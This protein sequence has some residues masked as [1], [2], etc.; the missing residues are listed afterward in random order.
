[1][2]RPSLTLDRLADARLDVFAAVVGLVLSLALLP[3]GLFTTEVLVHGV[4]ASIGLGCLFYLLATLGRFDGW[5]R[6][7]PGWRP[8]E[9]AI[10]ERVRRPATSVSERV[11]RPGFLA[12]IVPRLVVVGLSGLVVVA[13]V[14]GGRPL[15]FL[16]L[17]GVVGSLVLAQILFA[18]AGTLDHRVVLGEI[19]AYAL[20]VRYAAL[21]TT[22]GFVGID[23]WT[24]VTSFSAAIQEA[25]ALSPLAG[26]KY[27]ASP[28]YHLLTVAS[29]E[30]LGV[31]LRTALYLTVAAVMVLAVVL[32]FAT[33][34]YVVGVRGAL[35]ATMLFAVADYVIRWGLYVS[36]TSLGLVFFLAV[37]FVL[38]RILYVEV[39]RIDAVVLAGFAIAVAL[40]HQ[41]SAFI[42]MVLLGTATTV[43]FLSRY[44][45]GMDIPNAD[46]K[47]FA[48]VGVFFSFTLVQWAF[49]PWMGGT[50][51]TEGVALAREWLAGHTGFMNLVEHEPVEAGEEVTAGVLPQLAAYVDTLGLFLFLVVGTLGSLTLL[52]RKRSA[53]TYTYVGAI[54]VMM[55]ATL[56]LP[57]FGFRFLLPERWFAFAY[58]PMAVVGAVGVGY[59]ATQFWTRGATVA[60]FVFLLAFPSTMVVAHDATIDQP[61]FEQQWSQYAHSEAEI[62][63]AET[64]DETVPEANEPI[65]TDHPYFMAMTRLN[66][67]PAERAVADYS[68][69]AYM[70]TVTED[71]Q[72]SP[73]QEIVVYRSYQSEAHPAYRG[74]EDVLT[75]RQ[76]DASEVCPETRNHVYGA[77]DVRMC[78]AP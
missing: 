77:D 50:F 18:D 40:T 36:T 52:Q 58:A 26:I 25:G 5:N 31:S 21:L 32:V 60:L 41:V 30:L 68:Y 22:P 38:T 63:A 13:M 49:T 47:L 69:S 57:M 78:V 73:E 10:P 75:T 14:T 66:E 46:G 1:M 24:H 35:L 61:T 12:W 37:L 64:L 28:F 48:P 42:T 39:G 51:L 20:V 16:L 19:I 72:V 34:R 8:P 71:G 74:P 29:A 33:A 59:F 62:A 23:N 15:A 17:A 11:T 70:F 55:I 44:V 76:I 4:P 7:P 6:S 53:G 45:D 65:Y 43:V 56:G 2:S 54:S 3:L 9:L 27:Y 67:D